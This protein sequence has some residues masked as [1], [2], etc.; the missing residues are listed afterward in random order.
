MMMG[1]M[2][3]DRASWVR[4]PM[5]V[6]KRF[7]ITVFVILL[8][9]LC[10]YAS[11]R[12]YLAY[13]Y[14]YGWSHSCDKGLALGLISYAQQ[15]DGWFPRGETTPEASLSLLP[16]G[17]PTRAD[18]LRGKTVPLAVVQDRLDRGLR[19]TPETCGW[20]YVE[21]LRIDDNPELALFW[22]KAGLGHNGERI[23]GI[24]YVGFVDGF[25]RPVETTG[26]LWNEFLE[27]QNVLRAEQERSRAS[28]DTSAKVRDS[29]QE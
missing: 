3:L 13:R 14:P 9:V 16:H 21:G 26:N 7:S 5:V 18:I 24:R 27:R 4:P 12:I 29:S 28:Q 19:L 6:L 23:S 22:D 20:H 25:V 10:L 8:I 17:G 15:H 2:Q 11:G 1:D